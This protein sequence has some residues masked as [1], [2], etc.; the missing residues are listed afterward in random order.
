[1]ISSCYRSQTSVFISQLRSPSYKSDTLGRR[2]KEEDLPE[3]SFD[4]CILKES[5]AQL[6]FAL[7][8]SPRDPYNPSTAVVSLLTAL[9]GWNLVSFSLADAVGLRKHTRMKFYGSADVM[10]WVKATKNQVFKQLT[11]RLKNDERQRRWLTGSLMHGRAVTHMSEQSLVATVQNISRGDLLDIRK[12]AAADPVP[13]NRSQREKRKSLG[14]SSYRRFKL[15][16]T[17]ATSGEREGVLVS[18]QT[19]LEEMERRKSH[20]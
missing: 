18:I 20:C 10:V 19:C 16:L 5:A 14:Y 15:V 2:V 17:F 6:P 11:I 13:I 7:E 3:G 8:A 9:T 4:K 1:M 12:M